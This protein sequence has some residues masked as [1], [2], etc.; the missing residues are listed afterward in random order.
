MFYNYVNVGVWNIHGLFTKGNNSK[1]KKLED[2]ELK[3]KIKSFEILCLQETHCGPKDTSLLLVPG[4]KLFRSHRKMSG[5]GRY[6][7]GMLLLIKEEL[8]PGITVV[9]KSNEDKMWIKL[10]SEFFNLKKDL[11]ICFTYVPPIT[12]EYVKNLEYDLMQKMEEEITIYSGLGNVMIAGDF[13]AKTGTECD[14]VLDHQDKHSPVNI[15]DTYDFDEPL[16]RENQDKHPMDTQGE[17]FLNLCKNARLRILNG[18]TKG[19]RSGRFTRYPLSLR[20]SP[21]TLDYVVVDTMFLKD[22]E[23]FR[24][25][26]HL[27]LSDHECVSVSIKTNGFHAKEVQKVKV[28]KNESILYANKKYFLLKLRS[29]LGKERLMGFLDK[30]IRGREASIE[31]MYSDLVNILVNFSEKSK[32]SKLKTK[33]KFR[34]RKKKKKVTMVFQ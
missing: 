1:L 5:N 23:S 16:A 25:L 11:F 26:H 10:K 33:K 21:S 19:D 12:S 18:R 2:P 15:I 8:K 4:Y 3:R 13:N 14:F 22:I 28:V 27:G 30:Y 20:E 32:S 6:F 7:E 9:N 17:N 24:V 31:P 34:K 29:P